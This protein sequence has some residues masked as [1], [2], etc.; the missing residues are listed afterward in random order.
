M[1]IPYS[2]AVAARDPERPP[3]ERDR[4]EPVD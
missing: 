3:R 1:D 4:L 2:A